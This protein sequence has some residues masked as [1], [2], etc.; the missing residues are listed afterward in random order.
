MKDTTK[1]LGM[2]SVLVV[3]QIAVLLIV[4]FIMITGNNS[5]MLQ[6]V[7]VILEVIFLSILTFVKF[8]W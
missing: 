3:S 2:I 6:T 8:I 7:I 4:A 5:E 1:A